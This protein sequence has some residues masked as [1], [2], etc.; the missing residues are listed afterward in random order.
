VKHVLAPTSEVDITSCVGEDALAF[1]AVVVVL[2]DIHA[3]IGVLHL[4]VIFQFAD[5]PY[6]FF[7]LVLIGVDDVLWGPSLHS[8]CVSHV[9]L[10]LIIFISL[11][12]KLKREDLLGFKI[13]HSTL[14]LNLISN[15]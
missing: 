1:P 12:I 13:T 8:S 10:P 7:S 11:F 2:P 4:Y 14:L 3:P 5:P 9:T 15:I 6:V